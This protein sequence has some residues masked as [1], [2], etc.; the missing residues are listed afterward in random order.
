ML[1]CLCAIGAS[2][3][4][5]SQCCYRNGPYIERMTFRIQNYLEY[6]HTI[7]TDAKKVRNARVS[8][9]RDTSTHITRHTGSHTAS[10]NKRTFNEHTVPYL[11]CALAARGRTRGRTLLR[12]K[13]AHSMRMLHKKRGSGRSAATSAPL[14]TPLAG[15]VEPL[16]AP[17]LVAPP[18]FRISTFTGGYSCIYGV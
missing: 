1:E 18:R 3:C 7:Q 13:H 5:C 11:S 17:P 12:P 15:V 2:Q 14:A 16:V 9:R 8:G 6:T 4:S 10:R